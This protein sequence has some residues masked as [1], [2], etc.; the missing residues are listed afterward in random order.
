VAVVSSS[1][2][3]RA[4]SPARNVLSRASDLAL[5]RLRPPSRLSLA[6]R[7][8][9]TTTHATL[10][11][12]LHCSWRGRTGDNRLRCLQL[13][14]C[15]KHGSRI[16]MRARRAD[17]DGIRGRTRWCSAEAQDFAALTRPIGWRQ[18]A[19]PRRAPTS[20]PNCA[21]FLGST[22]RR[23]SE[24]PG[25]C[26]GRA[27]HRPSVSRDRTRP[28]KPRRGGHRSSSP[29]A[30]DAWHSWIRRPVHHPPGAQLDAVP[31]GSK[32]GRLPLGTGSCSG[33]RPAY[34]PCSR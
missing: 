29:A 14:R 5:H 10:L 23:K 26:R 28:A 8:E 15:G 21:C 24:E 33:S 19:G 17:P 2:R 11:L 22:G 12:E 3:V 4:R 16:V 20:I 7:R 27:V 18:A 9:W 31:R 32:P 1:G 13:A 34:S 25:R 30:C 6:P